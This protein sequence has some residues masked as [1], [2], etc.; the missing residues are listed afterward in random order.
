MAC[1]PD[2]IEAIESARSRPWSEVDGLGEL[3]P[4]RP[5]PPRATRLW[6][7]AGLLCLAAGGVGY[8]TMGPQDLSPDAPIE[9]NFLLA[10]EGWEITFDLED[11]AVLDIVALG[12]DGLA[13][14]HSGVRQQR[15]QWSTGDGDY[16]V[17]VPE[18]TV[19]LLASE[20]GVPE[21]PALVQRARA[22]PSPLEFLE[23]HVQ[24]E[25]PTVAWVASPAITT[26]ETAP[27][28]TGSE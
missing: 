22:Q 17:Y 25:Y 8:Q 3:P 26:D 9:A 20:G 7:M 6:V 27:V 15:G 13:V 10:E 11:L 1:C 4:P 5:A 19:V 24:T 14:V 21:L 12:S 28:R 18:K 2:A 16:R 23:Q